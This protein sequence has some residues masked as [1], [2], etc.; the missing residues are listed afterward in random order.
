MTAYVIDT[1]I[2]IKH[3]DLEDRASWGATIPQDATDDDLNGHGSHCSGTIAGKKY[4]VAKNANVVAVKALGDNG[5]GSMSDIIKAVEF[6]VQSHM[7]DATTKK[8]Y[9]GATAN[10]SLGGGKSNAVDYAINAAVRAGLYINIMV[11]KMLM[12]VILHQPVLN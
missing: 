7:K 9:K 11:M 4:G 1:G 8:G 10:L 2:N 12:L 3:T 6:V 5:S